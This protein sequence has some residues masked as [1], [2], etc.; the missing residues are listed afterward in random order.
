M[1]KWNNK[2]TD[3]LSQAFLS[4]KSIAEGK[5]FLRDLMTEKEI[6][7]FGNRLQAAKMLTNG[8]PYSDIERETKLS[9]TTI[10]RVSKW[11]LGGKGGYKLVLNRLNHHNSS[12][13]FRES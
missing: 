3:E 13:F 6:A 8:I 12:E 2:K 9:S 11:L 5:K 4:L 7:E 1:E 10:A